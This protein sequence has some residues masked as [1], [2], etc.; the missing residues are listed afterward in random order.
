MLSYKIKKSLK[1][2]IA[3]VMVIALFSSGEMSNT[4]STV[5]T[6][7]PAINTNT[8]GSAI[9]VK[10]VIK[11]DIDVI[12]IQSE[13][14]MD[15]TK[16]KE[17]SYSRAPLT[18]YKKWQSKSQYGQLRV[19]VNG[20]LTCNSEFE[21][22]TGVKHNA[23]SYVPFI[24]VIAKK[25]EKVNSLA[26]LLKSNGYATIGIHPHLKDFF[27]RDVVYPR[28]GI[29]K[30]VA[31]DSFKNPKRFGS[32]V[33]DQ[34]DF[35]MVLKQL[36][37]DNKRK[38]IFNVT[39]QNH[40]P[41]CSKPN[42]ITVNSKAFVSEEERISMQNYVTGL[43]H[44]D[45]ELDKFLKEIDK[46]KRRTIVVFY[47]D[48]QPPKGHK[49]F[50]QMDYFKKNGYYMT[51]YFIYDNKGKLAKT[52]ED[53]SLIQMRYEIESILNIDQPTH[54]KTFVVNKGLT[55]YDTFKVSEIKALYEEENK[56]LKPNTVVKKK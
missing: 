42:P 31:V 47:G 9:V 39:V 33:N 24:D 12:V 20:G 52:N 41:F 37:K 25:D 40:A 19:P 4:F 14:F 53:L 35:A 55:S 6:S 54:L 15:V 44:T 49:S 43:W 3:G 45:Q 51:D 48:H 16:I 13:A 30:F 36:K 56:K 11:E 34:T 46:R 17:M 10:P 2:L 1:T 8:S 28:L 5:N 50:A 18:N 32:W 27:N 26:W 29:D 38:F 21:L 7:G 22:L 23:I